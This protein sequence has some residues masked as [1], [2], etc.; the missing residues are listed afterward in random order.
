M[1]VIIV[2]GNCLT[3]TNHLWGSKLPSISF[4]ME[5]PAMQMLHSGHLLYTS[6]LPL[7]GR[8]SYRV[9]RVT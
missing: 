6:G 5:F 4:N 9:I 7:D 2:P 3:F 1:S 8:L